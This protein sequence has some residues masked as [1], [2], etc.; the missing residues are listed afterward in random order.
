M[1]KRPGRP[2]Y[3]DYGESIIVG[4]GNTEDLI[5]YYINGEPEPIESKITDDKSLR[6]HILSVIVTN[7]GIKRRDSRIFLT[8]I[9][10]STIKKTNNKICN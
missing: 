9:R 4:N 5:D 1:R 2:Q 6:T 10:R 7:P 3:D 8:N